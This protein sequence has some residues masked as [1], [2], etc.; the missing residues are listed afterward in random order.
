M[1]RKNLSSAA[2]DCLLLVHRMSER[3]E[4]PTTS[5]LA[6]ALGV[7]DSTVTAM[8]QKL[9]ERNLLNYKQRKEISLTEEGGKLALQLIRRHRIIETY[10]WVNLG[11]SWGDIH[12]EAEQIEHV[13]SDRFIE[14]LSERLGHPEVDPH[15][16]PI[17]TRY[18]VQAPRSSQ[19]P[20]SLKPQG[21]TGKL[22]R[23]LDTRS[24][25]L[26]YLE[27]LGL[28]VGVPIKVLA[29]QTPDHVLHVRI[30]NRE[31]VLGQPLA[32]QLLMEDIPV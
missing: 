4:A 20:L 12:E 9:A 7:T 32:S 3:Q 22:A 24:E 13:V 21:Y 19:S 2:E 31:C 14:A 10:L 18:G 1:H 26:A 30:G 15:G 27:G 11:Y 5:T 6:R 28:Y 25:S 8:I 23:V 29:A 16:D 17:P